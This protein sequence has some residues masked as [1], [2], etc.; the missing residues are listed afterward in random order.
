MRLEGKVVGPWVNECHRAW[1]AIRA[2]LGMKK[3]RLDIRSVTFMD[4]RGIALLR[5]IRKLSGAE[6]LADCPLTKYFAQRIMQEVET[7]GNLGV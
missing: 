2:E 1:Q 3:L 5:E 6:V 4:S 7:E